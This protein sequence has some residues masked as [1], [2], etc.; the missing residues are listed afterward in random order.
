MCYKVITH[1][2]M[3]DVRPVICDGNQIYVDPYAKPVP[4]NCNARPFILARFSC[5]DH[6]CCMR[7]EKMVYCTNEQPCLPFLYHRYEQKRCR[8]VWGTPTHW[9]TYWAD[10]NIFLPAWP[11][12]PLFDAGTNLH[13]ENLS[14]PVPSE[15]DHLIRAR[16]NVLTTGRLIASM[17]ETLDRARNRLAFLRERHYVRHGSC[18]RVLNPWE[19][20]DITPIQELDGVVH[21]MLRTLGRQMNLFRANVEFYQEVQISERRDER[22][23]LDPM[24]D[25]VGSVSSPSDDLAESF[26]RMSLYLTP[27][28]PS[29]T[30]LFFNPDPIGTVHTPVHE[31]MESYDDEWCQAMRDGIQRLRE[32]ARL[33]GVHDPGF[34]AAYLERYFRE[35]HHFC[36]ENCDIDYSEGELF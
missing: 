18:E 11:E 6:S 23:N 1:T 5:E 9:D 8:N 33:R 13:S 4:C 15:S 36:G 20:D 7:I 34:E 22:L 16:L 29:D 24:F 2:L 21:E 35:G 17:V 26:D 19:C 30:D 14:G 3:C 25:D 32:A 10:A 12:I 28:S 27:P 31:E